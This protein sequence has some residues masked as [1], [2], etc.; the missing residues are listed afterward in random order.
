[1]QLLQRT[2]A[3]LVSGTVLAAILLIALSGI[4]AAQDVP[5]AVTGQTDLRINEIMASNSTTL[6]DPDERD[7]TPDWIEIYNPTASPVS[8]TGMALTDDPADPLKHVITQSLTVPAN[9]F[10]IF[11]ADNDPEQGP[12]HLS[13]ALSAAGEY[14]GLYQ[15]G[16]SGAFSKVDETDF[17]ALATDL[18]YARTI[19]GGGIWQITRPTPGKRNSIDAPYISEV[20]TPTLSADLPAP[21]GPFTVTA[22]ITD[23]LNVATA[24]LVYYTATAPYTA[25]PPVWVTVTMASLGSN[26]YQAAIPALPANTLV[27]YYVHAVDDEEGDVRFPLPQREYGYLAG[28]RPPLLLINEVVSRNDTTFD[29]DEV[30]IFPTPETPDW[31]EVYNPGSQPVSLEGLS[32]TNDRREPLK[33]RVPAGA[34]IPAGGLVVFLADDDQGQNTLPGRTVWHMNFTL[35]N[36]NDFAGLYGGEGTFLIDFY[37]WDEP[38]RHGGFGR[39]PIGAAWT[40]KAPFVCPTLGVANVLCDQEV[41]LPAVLR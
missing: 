7:E 39:V 8:L 15:V 6:I 20:T 32:F 1:M 18:S 37:D 3:T 17:P 21:L 13:F 25:T 38:P 40:A 35:N 14:V 41:L 30:G 26:Y 10:L 36:T 23:N 29:P 28:Y 27:K 24:S 2:A 9:G 34:E 33:F 11:Y 19:D 12:A 22:T 5:T 4:A 16:A 31:I